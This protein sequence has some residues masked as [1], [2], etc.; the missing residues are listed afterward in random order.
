MEDNNHGEVADEEYEGILE[1][2]NPPEGEKL[3][4]K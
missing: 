2:I 3:R 4:R 1:G